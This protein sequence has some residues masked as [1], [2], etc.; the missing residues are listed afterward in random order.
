MWQFNN[1][2]TLKLS[3]DPPTPPPHHASSSLL[4][5]VLL[6]YVT[7]STKARSLPNKKSNFF[8]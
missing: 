6:R 8:L 7:L 4:T 2:V 3:F 5:K 1:Y